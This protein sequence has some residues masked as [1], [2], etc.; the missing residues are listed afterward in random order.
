MNKIVSIHQPSYFP[1]LGLLDKIYKSDTFVLLDNVQFNDNAFQSR[2][3]FLNHNGE[4]QYL[5]I[6]ISKKDYQNKTI[7]DLK[8]SDHRW[9]K[10]HKGFLTANYKK[11][12]YFDEIY[13]YIEDVYNKKYEY[14]IDV[15]YDSMKVTNDML[16]INTEI[17][18]ASDLDYDKTLTKDELVLAILK[19][20]D[21]K[22]YISGTGA[23]AYQDDKKFEDNNIVLKYQ[24]F[25]HPVYEQK[26]SSE[27]KMGLSILDVLFNLGCKK[28]E[29]LLK[30]GVV[31]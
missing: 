18:L 23:K 21:A 20:V 4:V 31:K 10:K 2:N 9:Q 1:W 15:L 25:K 5:S 12:P 14:L 26:N 29:N 17:I 7:R 27:F 3:I 6:P 8:I 16:N 30:E 11:H 19:S 13:P 24:E 28:S 22:E